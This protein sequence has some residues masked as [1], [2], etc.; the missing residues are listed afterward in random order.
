LLFLIQN[1]SLSVYIHI[2]HNVS[3]Y[4]NLV[5]PQVLLVFYLFKKFL[6]LKNQNKIRKDLNKTEDEL[7]NYRRRRRWAGGQPLHSPAWKLF[8]QIWKYS[9]KPEKINEDLFCILDMKLILI[10]LIQCEKRR[11]F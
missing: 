9:G 6:N 4:I 10:T 1:S 8:G 11:K 7:S 5:Q 2:L 3:N